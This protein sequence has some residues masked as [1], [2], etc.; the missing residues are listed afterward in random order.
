[1]YQSHTQDC[2]LLLR[3]FNLIVK[4]FCLSNKAGLCSWN[5]PV[6]S[7]EC[8]VSC[9]SKQ[10]AF[11]VFKFMAYKA[12]HHLQAWPFCPSRFLCLIEIHSQISQ[13]Y[14]VTTCIKVFLLLY[15]RSHKMIVQCYKPYTNGVA[16]A[17]KYCAIL[18]YVHVLVN[19]SNAVLL[20]TWTHAHK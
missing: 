11:M 16:K 13:T 14:N 2:W 7:N 15:L 4:E 17:L 8:I 12:I 19:A 6:L 18:V 3:Y 10:R 9:S 1:M 5:Q 20:H